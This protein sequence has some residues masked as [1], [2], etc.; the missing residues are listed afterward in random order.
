MLVAGIRRALHLRPTAYALLG[1]LPL[2]AAVNIATSAAL[3]QNLPKSRGFLFLIAGMQLISAVLFFFV[4][5][6]LERLRDDQRSMANKPTADDFDILLGD[7]QNSRPLA[8]ALVGA[9]LALL[10]SLGVMACAG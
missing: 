1:G 9:V 4:S 3:G 10:G 8:L 7:P 6:T 2:A 5:A